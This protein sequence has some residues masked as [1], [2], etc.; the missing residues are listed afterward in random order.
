MLDGSMHKSVT[1]WDR[2]DCARSFILILMYTL[3][4]LMIQSSYCPS[5]KSNCANKSD[6]I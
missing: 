6:K 4:T 3:I 2:D 1:N 5:V